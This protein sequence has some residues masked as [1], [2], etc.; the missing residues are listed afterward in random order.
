MFKSIKRANSLA[1]A[2]G[3]ARRASFAVA[4]LLLAT[5]SAAHAAVVWNVPT[6]TASWNTATNWNPNTV[7]NAV[8]ESAT[9]NNAASPSNP[10]QTGN[11]TITADGA[12]TVGSI[13]FNNDAAN[14][15][16][17]SIT[18]GASGS[19]IFDE[20][21]SGSATIAVPAGAGTG[22]NTISAPM[23]LNDNLVANV[24]NVNT[25]SATG[26][27]NLTA[28]ISGAGGFTKNGPGMATF[29]TG[30]KTYTG[31]TVIDGGRTRISAA[32][33]PSANSSF[34]I[35]SGGQVEFIAAS[36]TYSFGGNTVNLNG[37]GPTTG[38]FAA[39]PG[40]IRPTR[41]SGTVAGMDYTI[42]APVNLQSDTLIHVEANAGTGANPLGSLTFTN[43]IAGPGRLTF[44]APNS[45]VDQGTLVL[46]G[47][48]SY[49][50][51][52]LVAGGIVQ[53]TGAAADL[54]RG[55]VTVD[56]ASSLASIARLAI[57]TGVLNA[58]DD[59]ATLTLAGGGTPGLADRNFAIL[60]AGVNETVGGLVLGGVAQTA[61][62]T[63]GSSASGATFVNDEYFS[64]PGVITLA[65]P[66]PAA[67]S[68]LALAA[69]VRAG[70]RRRK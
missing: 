52:T 48:N 12:Q 40:A 64:G 30:A 7:P 29:G 2:R 4:G 16:T 17:N 62:G 23:V 66:E 61:P 24:D 45:D 13:V 33:H 15:F 39:F 47:D 70:R 65:I 58:I 34:T 20:A 37:S 8:G 5:G 14:S 35:N 56:N 44:T 60:N 54:G 38:P 6:G 36:G 69:G 25:A 57:S 51:G 63:Y 49:T 31:P 68:L 42:T 27:L 26:A 22:N 41:G 3:R 32:A 21:G 11:R 28:V 53:V 1:A 43:S 18:V 19:L 67:L 46:G 50:G 10:A 9:F 59:A 55:N